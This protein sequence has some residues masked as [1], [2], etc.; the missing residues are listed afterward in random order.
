MALLIIGRSVENAGALQYH[1]AGSI[2]VE[3][4][5]KSCER[6]EMEISEIRDY[7]SNELERVKKIMEDLAEY[8]VQNSDKK[9][10]IS[11]VQFYNGMM[12]AYNKVL[13][14]IDDSLETHQ[15]T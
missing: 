11:L 3:A 2:P 6:I 12:I 7:V 4:F 13:K 15:S 1:S 14:T 9:D 10:D 5:K 8:Y